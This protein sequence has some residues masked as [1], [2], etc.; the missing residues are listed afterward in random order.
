MTSL[1][2]IVSS[3]VMVSHTEGDKP[4]KLSAAAPVSVW[5]YDVSVHV[6]L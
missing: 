6:G 1:G 4:Y 5:R 2:Q 3:V